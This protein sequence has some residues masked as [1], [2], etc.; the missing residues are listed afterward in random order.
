MGLI[1]GYEHDIFVSF[2][3]ADDTNGDVDENT[4][5]WVDATLRI[6]EGN[7]RKSLK[8]LIK[9][10]GR[11]LDIFWSYQLAQDRPLDDNIKSHIE[12]SALFLVVMSK[13]FLNSDWCLNKEFE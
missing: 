11:D 8:P 7:L 9:K 1:P 10:T 12:K 4:P 3:H 13:H 2:A 5:G 6:L